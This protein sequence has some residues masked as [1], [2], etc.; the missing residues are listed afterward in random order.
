MDMKVPDGLVNAYL[1]DGKGGGRALDWD[2]VR[3]WKPAD[4]L[5]WIH[6]CWP[7]KLASDWV[8]NE[9]GLDPII[10]DA[11]LEED[12]RPRCVVHENGM[13]LILRGVNLTP[14]AE[15]SDMVSIRAW[16][17][18]NRVITMYRVRLIAVQDIRDS[19]D[20][21]KGP[22]NSGDF[23]VQLAQR[24]T[25]RVLPVEDEIGEALD[26]LEDALVE[27]KLEEIGDRLSPLRR[28]TIALRR[29]LAPQREALLLLYSDGD[30]WLDA[31]Q[32]SRIREIADRVF[33]IIE[34]LDSMRERAAIIQDERRTRISESMDKAIYNLSIIATIILPL[35]FVTGLFG[36]NVGG[37]P[38]KEAGWAFWLV[39]GLL[40]LAGVAMVVIFRRI[41]W[42]QAGRDSASPE[43]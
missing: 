36:M 40:I 6:L 9:S 12:T 21:A 23:V 11:L 38:G 33:R 7:E 26:D 14:G 25:D 35:T 18:S 17:D 34:E 19:L 29:H 8:R 39:T 15:P 13:M 5:F 37:I 43:K 16:I 1:L 31:R 20:R 10:A 3:A 28:E 2:G 4:G 42:L 27:D 22:K 41:R 24:L 32:R 30:D